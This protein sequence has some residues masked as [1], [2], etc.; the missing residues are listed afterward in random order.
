MRPAN[1]ALREGRLHSAEV[2]E[3]FRISAQLFRQDERLTLR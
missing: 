2:T 3:K 1:P